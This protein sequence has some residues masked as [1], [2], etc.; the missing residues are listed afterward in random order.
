MQYVPSSENVADILT[1]P[2]PRP[3]FRK[4]RAKLMGEE[5]KPYKFEYTGTLA[6]TGAK[7]E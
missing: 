4:L 2:L 7:S 1:K 6:T 3:A 5:A